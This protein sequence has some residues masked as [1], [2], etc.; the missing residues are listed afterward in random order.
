MLF[1]SAKSGAIRS[2][3]S[4]RLNPPEYPDEEQKLLAACGL[5]L[6]A[7]VIA[8]IESGVRRGEILS[9]QW[10]QVEG[11]TIEDDATV[12]WAPKPQLFLPK[13]KT[14][15]KRIDGCRSRVA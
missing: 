6:K 7:I 15:K 11:M 3:R 2:P 8:A 10:S 13:E 9:F 1:R 4:R 14:K 5:H 12:T